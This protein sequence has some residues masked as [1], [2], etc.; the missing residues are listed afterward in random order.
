MEK[1]KNKTFTV[2][3]NNKEPSKQINS[4]IEGGEMKNWPC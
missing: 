2:T 3:Q 1:N 4:Q